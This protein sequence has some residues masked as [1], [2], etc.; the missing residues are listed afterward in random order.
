M[1]RV[2]LSLTCGILGG[3]LAAILAVEQM[4][5]TGGDDETIF[6]WFIIGSLV[7]YYSS[8]VIFEKVPTFTKIFSSAISYSK[9]VSEGIKVAP[10]FYAVAEQEIL[11][12][13]VDKG[14]WAKALV[15][16]KG[17][18][19]ARKAEYIKLRARKLQKES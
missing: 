8:Y 13:D 15:N 19:D 3:F 1:L 18:E 5:H 9:D 4:R 14:L 10:E 12:N 16:A 11:E 17:N 6:I 2:I 7:S